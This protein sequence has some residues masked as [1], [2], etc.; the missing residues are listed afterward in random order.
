VRALTIPFF[1]FRF[2]STYL[3]KRELGAAMVTLSASDKLASKKRSVENTDDDNSK[4][5]QKS[6]SIKMAPQELQLVPS[7]SST[8]GEIE[9]E[10]E[11]VDDSIYRQWVGS[12]V[13]INTKE[14]IEINSRYKFRIGIL[15]HEFESERSCVYQNTWVQK[16]RRYIECQLLTY[17]G[18]DTFRYEISSKNYVFEARQLL[19]LDLVMTRSTR[20]C[21]AF[22]EEVREVRSLPPM[23]F[24][25]LKCKKRTR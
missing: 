20:H 21:N 11:T 10:P 5:L 6:K 24:Q 16:G 15:L 3:I 1:H 2:L 9:A 7:S 4:K 18:D 8:Q 22:W 14:S 19:P 17:E 12:F 23:Y 13:A 25:L